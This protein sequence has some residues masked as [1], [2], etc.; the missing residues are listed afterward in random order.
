[1]GYYPIFVELEGRRVLVVGGGA[2][3]AQKMRNLHSAGPSITVIAPEL[4]EEMREYH[5]E[6]QFSW[7]ERGY[8]SGDVDGYDLVMVATDDGLVNRQVSSE[9]R[10]RRIW[11]NAADD[12]PNCDF[13]LPS[14][15]RRGSLVLCA[16]T[17]GGSPALARRVRETLEDVFE[18]WWADLAELLKAVRNE[19]RERKVMFAPDTWKEAMDVTFID[20]VRKGKFAEAQTRLWGRLEDRGG[21]PLPE[22]L[23]ELDRSRAAAK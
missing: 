20:L 11:V 8:E 21:E 14:M 13:I 15:V 1:M 7:T 22:K 2:V 10:E 17:G 6:A 18:P 23:Q 3:A 4:K 16:S 12:I 5:A 19:T 9:A